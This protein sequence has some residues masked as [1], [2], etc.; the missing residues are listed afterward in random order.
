VR[1]RP[2]D[3]AEWGSAPPNATF[4]ATY[5]AVKLAYMTLWRYERMKQLI[6]SDR[7]VTVVPLEGENSGIC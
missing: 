3:F 4:D 5:A 6:Q 1:T 7:L 2:K